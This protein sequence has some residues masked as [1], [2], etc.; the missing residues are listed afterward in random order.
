M[1]FELNG[2]ADVFEYRWTGVTDRCERQRHRGLIN[3]PFTLKVQEYSYTVFALAD[4]I[5]MKTNIGLDSAS[6]PTITISFF[7][8]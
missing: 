2:L 7:F 1:I 6:N 4:C 3:P 8:F 5:E